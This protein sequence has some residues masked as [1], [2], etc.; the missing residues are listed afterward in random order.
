MKSDRHGNWSFCWWVS[1]SCKITPAFRQAV[2]AAT[3]VEWCLQSVICMYARVCRLTG[4][5]KRGVIA[6][7]ASFVHFK[8]LNSPKSLW[9]CRSAWLDTCSWMQKLSNVLNYWRSD[10]YNTSTEYPLHNF[11]LYFSP[12]LSEGLHQAGT[13]ES[14]W[15]VEKEEPAAHA[16]SLNNPGCTVFTD[17]CNLLL[18]LVMDVSH[19]FQCWYLYVRGVTWR[20]KYYWFPG[21][22]LLSRGIALWRIR[23]WWGFQSFVIETSV[24]VVWSSDPAWEICQAYFH[25]G[26]S[27]SSKLWNRV[28]L[29]N[30]AHNHGNI[31]IVLFVISGRKEKLQRSN[32]SSEGR[33]WTLVWW[34]SLSRIQWDE[35]I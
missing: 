34:P 9:K 4:Q 20:W 10:R 28:F 11:K 30:C 27:Q 22:K 14:L 19:T 35:S 24:T 18:K 16:F 12:G 13:A 15:A 7:F 21:Y 31:S 32:T 5:L 29:F 33:G 6:V 25:M 2:R 8:L 23:F 1:T 26:I 17:D 3:S